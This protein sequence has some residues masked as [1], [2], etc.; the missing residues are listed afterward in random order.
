M[1][2]NQPSVASYTLDVIT[3]NRSCPFTG[4]EIGEP[5]RGRSF[6]KTTAHVREI[7]SRFA[8]V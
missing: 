1:V 7:S 4:N 2:T 6:S 8:V 3:P 5:K